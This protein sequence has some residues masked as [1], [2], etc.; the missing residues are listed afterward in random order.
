MQATLQHGIVA[1]EGA[2]EGPIYLTS[3]HLKTMKPAEVRRLVSDIDQLNGGP[4]MEIEG[5]CPGCKK[6]FKEAINW[7]HGD[8]FGISSR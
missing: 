5:Q 8:F 7:S 4:V 6:K 2:P 3:K 1:I